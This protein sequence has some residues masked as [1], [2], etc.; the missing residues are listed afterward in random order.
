MSRGCVRCCSADPRT[1]EWSR[2]FARDVGVEIFRD[3]YNRR[4]HCGRGPRIAITDSPGASMTSFARTLATPIRLS[5][6]R[7]HTQPLGCIEDFPLTIARCAAS[8]IAL[9]ADASSDGL[10]T[11]LIRLEHGSEVTCG[12][13]AV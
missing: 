7:H 12:E 11:T 6:R 3:G 10:M 4:V 1:N 8:G 5:L 9:H 13:E 2:W